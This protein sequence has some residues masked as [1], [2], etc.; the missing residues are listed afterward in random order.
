VISCIKRAG[1]KK[2]I[3][4]DGRE[5]SGLSLTHWERG[6][7]SIA[8][9][10]SGLGERS[11]GGKDELSDLSCFKAIPDD[12]LLR[13]KGN[14]FLRDDAQSEIAT[15]LSTSDVSFPM[16]RGKNLSHHKTR[17]LLIEE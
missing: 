17:G 3:S 1:V 2:K 7:E 11:K 14:P 10:V 13:K 4:N 16:T 6:G 12:C 8:L 5:K 9:Q 15:F